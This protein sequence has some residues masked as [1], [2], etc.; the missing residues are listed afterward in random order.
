MAAVIDR[1][2][3]ALFAEIAEEI[4]NTGPQS[5]IYI[6]AFTAAIIRFR[7][8]PVFNQMIT[9]DPG[10]ALE[11]AHEHYAAA[12]A[13]IVAALRVIFPAGFAERVG[14]QTVSALADAI[15]RYSLMVLLLPSL[16]SIDTPDEIRA[17]ATAHFLPSLPAALRANS[18]REYH[19]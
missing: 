3:Q 7:R 2:N 17:F 4:K 13:R 14:P 19:W 6:E 1:E 10:L 15:L 9:E 16:E 8:H 12:V 11:L 18:S 5:N